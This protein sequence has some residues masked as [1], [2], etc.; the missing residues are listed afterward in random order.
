MLHIIIL[1]APLLSLLGAHFSF[2]LS[3]DFV[4]NEYEGE[5]LGII[6]SSILNKAI[7][8]FIEGVETCWVRQI[9][10][11]GAAIGSSVE[12]EA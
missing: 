10:A 11:E 3:V 7:L 5:V 6:R 12:C 8:P 1:L 2:W 4:A 9:V